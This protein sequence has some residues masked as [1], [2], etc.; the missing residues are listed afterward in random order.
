MSK[1][2]TCAIFLIILIVA[3]CYITQH[4]HL[5]SSATGSH[6]H[7]YTQLQMCFS[8]TL[9]V[10]GPKWGSGAQKAAFSSSPLVTTQAVRESDRRCLAFL[11]FK[12]VMGKRSLRKWRP[13]LWRSLCGV[14]LRW[15]TFSGS[16]SA[17]EHNLVHCSLKPSW[18]SPWSRKQLGFEG[19][20]TG[21]GGSNT[22][23]YGAEIKASVILCTCAAHRET[24]KHKP[25][26]QSWCKILP[27]PWCKS[28]LERTVGGQS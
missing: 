6:T 4:G 16:T 26:T 17:R 12:L 22:P 19:R 5:L 13:H 18:G 10:R 23:R 2:S 28:P 3:S 24:L 1:R 20:F 9:G 7:T 8:Y 27:S 21:T 25:L 15:R 14:F 11:S